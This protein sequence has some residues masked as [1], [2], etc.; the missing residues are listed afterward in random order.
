[1]IA[2]WHVPRLFSGSDPR[3]IDRGGYLHGS[4]IVIEKNSATVYPLT[5]DSEN[6]SKQCITRT[7]GDQGK[8]SIIRNFEVD[9]VF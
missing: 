1:M 9:D 3:F 7:T 8:C 5:L 4:V 2:D 6:F